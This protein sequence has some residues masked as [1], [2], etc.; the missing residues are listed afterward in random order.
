[1]GASALAAAV[2]PLSTS[3]A[4]SEA[5]GSERSVGKSFREAPIFTGLF[6]LQILIGASVALIP[7]NLIKTLINTQ[8]L[9]GVITPI[10]L[11]YILI[12]ANKRSLL[13][14]AANGPVFKTIATICVAAI[15]ALSLAVTIITVAGWLGFS[16]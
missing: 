8:I 4:V 10:I 3:Y 5:I 6:T 14:D 13:G 16:I 2:V 7:S 15:G 12:L 9:N 11:V 1:M